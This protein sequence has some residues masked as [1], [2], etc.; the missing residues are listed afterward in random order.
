M[1]TFINELGNQITVDV[2]EKEIDGVGGVMITI[3]GP[4][5][6]SENHVT[7]AEAKELSEQLVKLLPKV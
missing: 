1:K 5:S 7:T 6:T 2:V 3:E 4:T